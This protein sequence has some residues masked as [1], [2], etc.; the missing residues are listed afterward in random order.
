MLKKVFLFSNI[1]DY[2]DL[3]MLPAPLHATGIYFSM[4]S[5]EREIRKEFQESLATRTQ[6]TT[7]L[8]AV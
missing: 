1:P 2:G 8:P 7:T 3:D 6:Q 5:P 4:T